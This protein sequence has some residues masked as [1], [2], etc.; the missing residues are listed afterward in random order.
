MLRA[1]RQELLK[2]PELEDQPR[3][4]LIAVDGTEDSPFL[5]KEIAHFL[6]LQSHALR[7]QSAQDLCIGENEVVARDHHRTLTV[8]NT[9]DATSGKIAPSVEQVLTARKEMARIL[10]RL[11]GDH[12]AAKH[13]RQDL[14]AAR[15]ALKYL[16]TGKRAVQEECDACI[17]IVYGQVPR[18]KEKIKVVHPHKSLTGQVRL[19]GLGIGAVEDLKVLPSVLVK[20]LVG[21]M[22]LLDESGVVIKNLHVVH[23][24]PEE[25]VAELQMLLGHD[26]VDEHRQTG[27]GREQLSDL[28]TLLWIAGADAWVPHERDVQSLFGPLLLETFLEALLEQGDYLEGYLFRLFHLPRTRVVALQPKGQRPEDGEDG[29]VGRQKRILLCDQHLA[30]IRAPPPFLRAELLRQRIQH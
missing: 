24:R 5:P 19:N 13:A 18:H 23:H 15:D 29:V 12:L 9:Q 8:A 21:V 11:E 7:G 16:G 22:A 28:P 26:L 30:V 20:H 27:V 1:L 14:L 10:E 17:R 25:G 3:E 6:R 2:G 4:R